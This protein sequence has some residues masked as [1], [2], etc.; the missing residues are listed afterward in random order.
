[1]A[2]VVPVE[3][4]D[5][6]CRIVVELHLTWASDEPRP[7]ADDGPL[8]FTVDQ[9]AEQLSISRSHCW[10]LATEGVLPSFRLGKSIRIPARQLAEWVEQQSSP[11]TV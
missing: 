7:E 1:M 10:R 6:G 4:G 2:Q 3:V 5:D 9:A 8:A 11:D